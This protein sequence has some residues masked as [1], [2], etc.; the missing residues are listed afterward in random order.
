M[1][2]RVILAQA[3]CATLFVIFCLLTLCCAGA[4]EV[5]QCNQCQAGTCAH[6]S[7][8]KK[9]KGEEEEEEED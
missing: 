1:S 2:G 8:K 4:Y 9:K 5:T 7:C 6:G 3:R